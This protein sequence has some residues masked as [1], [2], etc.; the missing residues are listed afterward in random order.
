M[1]DMTDVTLTYNII[2]D[3]QHDL[4]HFKMA[5][6]CVCGGCSNSNL[7][8]QRVHRLPSQKNTISGTGYFPVMVLHQFDYQK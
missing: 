5:I 7:N 8:E 1:R 6:T 2:T 3:I 4:S